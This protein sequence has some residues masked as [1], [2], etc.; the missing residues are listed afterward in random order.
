[1][2]TRQDF[3][4][5]VSPMEETLEQV[6]ATLRAHFEIVDWQGV[7]IILA[8]AAAHYI[9]AEMLWLRF[10]GP[11][12]SGRT[13]LLR[14][15]T[16]HP[17]CAEM[18]VLTLAAFRGGFR[19]GPKVLDRTR[20][21]LV[22]TK[23]IASILTSR[24]DLR[25]EIFGVLRGIKDGKLTSDFGSDEGHLVQQASFDWILAATSSG[26]EQQRQLEGLLGQRFID[27]RWQPGNREEMAY[28]A[29]KNNP[30]LNDVIRP[31]LALDVLSL[32]YRVEKVVQTETITLSDKELREIARIANS[33]AIAR[34]LVQQDRSGNLI[35]LPDP[36]VGTDIAQGFSRISAGLLSLG[37]TDCH[38]YIQRLAWDCIP[39]I[40]TKLLR[41]LEDKPKTVP[42][43][44]KD[45]DIPERS[46]YYHID[47]LE[48]LKAVKDT[49]GVK[50][51][52]IELP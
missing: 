26:I 4:L 6:K 36:E 50:E 27:L 2:K 14:A 42:E 49:S 31:A 40:R 35:A 48:L 41:S 32:L 24:K 51:V 7:E 52:I 25:T 12:R 1:M 47:Q 9:P 34:T 22:I 5:E 43:L 46:V 37:L 23:D 38:P 15:V 8:T 45:T 17:D 16:E 29:A 44:A 39:S 11:S 21:K 28:Q 10:I 18:E 30:Y 13:E 3:E 20:G 19:K 33:V